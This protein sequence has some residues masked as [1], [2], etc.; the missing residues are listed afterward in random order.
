MLGI[1]RPQYWYTV[2]TKDIKTYVVEKF[3]KTIQIEQHDK[4]DERLHFVT[5]NVIVE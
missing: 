3:F 1:W 4:N 5:I 2:A